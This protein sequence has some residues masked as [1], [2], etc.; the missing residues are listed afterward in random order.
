MILCADIGATKTLLGLARVN[1]LGGGIEVVASQRYVA[2]EVGSFEAMLDGFLRDH[3][4][5]LTQPLRAACFGVAGPVND[6]QV[7]M[8]N[9]SWRLD[10]ATLSQRLGD[11]PVRLANDFEAAASGIDLLGGDQL[12]SLQAGQPITRAP[13]LVIGA[14]SGLGVAFRVWQP[15]GDGQTGHYGVVT[16]EGGHFSFTP[17]NDEQDRA[18]MRLRPHVARPVAEHFV[19][20]PGLANFYTFLDNEDSGKLV[21]KTPHKVAT[22]MDTTGLTGEE[23]ARRATQDGE[24]RA[25]HA[26]HHFLLSYG[27]V[28]G[29][30]A[31]ATLAR[32]G[33][34]LAGGIAQ[35]LG[36]VMQ[37][38]RFLVGFHQKG[39]YAGLMQTIPV[40][41]VT[42]P[43]LGLL[44]A[45]VIGARI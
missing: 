36:A 37:D 4:S 15:S 26:L 44:G 21:D 17:A 6:N 42:A 45:A 3:A 16:G 32:G 8:T 22:A 9:L 38:G 1:A 11:I 41:V 33:V 43:D 19:S 40:H 7:T 29:D 25:L 10:A 20:G 27:V 30:Y 2:A 12:L 23:V 31:L 28:A 5:H 35:K 24:P 13:Q 14:G 39:P 34:F 18:L